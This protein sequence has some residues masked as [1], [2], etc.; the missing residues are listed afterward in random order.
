MAPEIGEVTETA[1]EPE[2]KTEDTGIVEATTVEKPK[3]EKLGKKKKEVAS[4]TEEK[5]EPKLFKPPMDLFFREID[6]YITEKEIDGHKIKKLAYK[7]GK[8]I[9]G[10]PATSGKDF[11]VIAIKARKKTKSVSGKS[12]SVYYFG[13]NKKVSLKE[14][15]ATTHSKF[16]KCSVQSKMPVEL[17][18]DKIT[19]HEQFE[20]NQDKVILVLHQLIDIAIEHKTEDWTTLKEKKA[21]K[22][23]S[24]KKSKKKT[25]SAEKLLLS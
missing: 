23:T 8:I 21:E 18:L 17:K 20:Q 5:K 24:T 7:C 11:R 9:F 4:D 19:Y 14:F 25:E 22:E 3:P 6:S 10:I 1:I 16:G 12:R 13:F 15:P 2:V